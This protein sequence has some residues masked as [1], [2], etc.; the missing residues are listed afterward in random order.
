[1]KLREWPVRGE[2]VHVYSPTRGLYPLFIRA[3]K[4]QARSGLELLQFSFTLCAVKRTNARD[5]LGSLFVDGGI[6]SRFALLGRLTAGK[7]KNPHRQP[8]KDRKSH[9]SHG[10]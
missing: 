5:L 8:N 3:V 9:R 4:I 10:R 2:P 1:S 7:G 6:L